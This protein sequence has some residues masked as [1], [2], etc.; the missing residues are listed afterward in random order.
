M[1]STLSLYQEVV[2]HLLAN[3][4]LPHFERVLFQH[5]QT[6]SDF[7]ASTF[8]E[9]TIFLSKINQM[10]S[11]DEKIA[12]IKKHIVRKLT[13][14]GMELRFKIYQEIFA[15]L[16]T[17]YAKKLA[18]KA[19]PTSSN[20]DGDETKDS[21]VDIVDAMNSGAVYG[22]I[23]FSSFINIIQRCSPLH[24]FQSEPDRTKTF[25]DLGHGTG[26]ALIAMGLLYGDVFLHIHGIEYAPGLYNESINRINMYKNL[27][28]G[29][30][31][32][33]DLFA[34][35]R[36]S[37]A[38]L[39]TAEEGD[40]LATINPVD[41]Q[42]IPPQLLCFDWTKAGTFLFFFLDDNLLFSLT[43]NILILDI[44]FA[45]S[46]CYSYDMITQISK[47]GERMRKNSLLITLTYPLPNALETSVKRDLQGNII[48]GKAF[49]I[50][51][52]RNYPMSWGVATSFIH[53]KL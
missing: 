52:T 45:N 40:F 2:H 5:V 32:Y 29:N 27:I 17:D 31:Y 39:I 50:I 4:K 20:N 33:R 16:P 53:K 3:E 23:E 24:L 46:T 11:V 30:E 15:D 44:V 19:T 37:K 35:D 12:F 10:E 47:L 36:N 28:S 6:S 18:K 43:I 1:S 7:D 42:D 48:H 26:K 41:E 8:A 21:Q 13:Q 25:I 51:D 38:P 22:E 49:E 9:N 14:L 34:A